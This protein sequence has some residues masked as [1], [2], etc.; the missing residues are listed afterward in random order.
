[1]DSHSTIKSHE[2]R[3]RG[4]HPGLSTDD[5]AW[6]AS[7]PGILRIESPCPTRI[8]I[9]YDLHH[10]CLRGILQLVAW[11]GLHLDASLWSKLSYALIEYSEDAQRE[12]LNI[13]IGTHEALRKLAALRDT[14]DHSHTLPDDPKHTTAHNAWNRYL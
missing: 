11:R 5:A 8:K 1:M 2:I 9:S 4:P 12:T 3:L 13:P 7:L 6:L 10:I 14:P